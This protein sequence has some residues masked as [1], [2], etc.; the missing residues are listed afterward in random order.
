MHT[1]VYDG[2]HV[3]VGKFHLW[4]FQE[5]VDSFNQRIVIHHISDIGVLDVKATAKR[6]FLG[7]LYIRSTREAKH[8]AERLVCRCPLRYDLTELNFSIRGMMNLVDE[9]RERRNL[10]YCMTKFIGYRQLAK[11]IIRKGVLY[12]LVVLLPSIQNYLLG[13]GYCHQAHHCPI[14]QVLVYLTGIRVLDK[15]AILGTLQLIQHLKLH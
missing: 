9:N 13:I 2:K 8:I 11:L 14:L 1:I 6:H 7:F 4:S 5:V 10:A 12:F 15:V 3:V